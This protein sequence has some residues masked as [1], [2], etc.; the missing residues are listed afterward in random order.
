MTE[1]SLAQIKRS[2]IT[3]PGK[4]EIKEIPMPEPARDQVL[5]KVHSC[6]ICTWEQRMYSGAEPMYPMAG[7]HEV[8]GVVVKAGDQVFGVEPGDHVTAAGL[9]RC[10]QC[11]SCLRGYDNI[12]ENMWKMRA[13]EQLP[14]PGGL[15][16]YIL[17]LGKDVFKVSKDVPL[18]H[19]S[20]S[21]PLAC[22]LRSV[23]RAEI[24][25]GERVV[26]IG[27]GLMGLLHLMLAKARGAVVIVSE[28]NEF[29][30][31]KAREVGADYVFNP[32]EEDYVEKMLELSDGRGVDVT[33]VCVAHHSTVEPAVVGSANG[34]RVLLYSSFH[35]KKQKIEID[36]NIVHKK[37]VVLTG[38]MSQSRQDFFEASQ[39]ISNGNIDLAS[40]IS[41][42]YG[43]DQLDE[44]FEAAM[45]VETYRVVVNP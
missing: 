10:G 29:R 19:V 22:V 14:G 43:L 6:A 44:A 34:G 16:E 17:R 26:I 15:G 36:P 2:V 38:T 40:L 27:A 5:V 4:L 11:E 37:E 35:P 1:S 13:N 24:Q 12:C 8:S 33:F 3:A 45:S 21:E 23:K 32:M 31:N 39:L 9:N 30:A 28:P 25:A 18:A 41:V 20:L 42:T 7:G